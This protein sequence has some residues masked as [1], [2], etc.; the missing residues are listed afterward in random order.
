MAKGLD[1]HRVRQNIAYLVSLAIA[2]CL[3]TWVLW[4]SF[5]NNPLFLFRV[6]D[7][8][9]CPGVHSSAVHASRPPLKIH[10][11]QVIAEV[12]TLNVEEVCR[13]ARHCNAV[14]HLLDNNAVHKIYC[15][16]QLILRQWMDDNKQS[17]VTVED[18]IQLTEDRNLVTSY[19]Q[20][21]RGRIKDFLEV[22]Y[23]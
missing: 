22:R 9:M 20:P 11:K 18:C 14:K 17:T 2:G 1:R 13:T 23:Y 19:R 8:Q 21:Q 3:L 16:L 12:W 5:A 4:E 7:N 6:N 15:Y 10:I